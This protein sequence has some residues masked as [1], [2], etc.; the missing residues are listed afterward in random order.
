MANKTLQELSL[1]ELIKKK[2]TIRKLV[3]GLGLLMIMAC[4]SLVILSVTTKKYVFVPI[5]TG[6]ILTLLPTGIALSQIN[7]EIKSRSAKR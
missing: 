4:T 1:E 5:A 6:C 3:L 2:K 7:K